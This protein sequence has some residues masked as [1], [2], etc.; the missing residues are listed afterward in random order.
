M[1]QNMQ[2]DI[3]DSEFPPSPPPVIIPHYS[4]TLVSIPDVL[5]K[6]LYRYIY[7]WTKNN[8]SFWMYPIALSQCNMLSG[9]QWEK[10][11]WRQ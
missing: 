7:L 2:P 8:E 4:K 1:D 11:F 9:Y 10:N 3:L 6:Y 5:D